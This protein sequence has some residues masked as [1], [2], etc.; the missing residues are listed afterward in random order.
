MQTDVTGPPEGVPLKHPLVME[1]SVS[2]VFL[3]SLFEAFLVF[4]WRVPW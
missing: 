2:V 3:S 1:E 4:H